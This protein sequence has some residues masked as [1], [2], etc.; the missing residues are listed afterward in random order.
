MQHIQ[1]AD[2]GEPF[3]I[4]HRLY[5]GRK[6]F[7]SHQDTSSFKLEWACY[8]QPSF[9]E[10]IIDIQKSFRT[11]NTGIEARKYLK[12]INEKLDSER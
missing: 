11:G 2:A 10:F 9:L 12:K 5:I 4:F 1:K 6:T 3:D 7:E 8:I